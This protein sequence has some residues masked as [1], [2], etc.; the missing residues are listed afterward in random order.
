METRYLRASLILFNLAVLLALLTFRD[1]G[2]GWDEGV[3]HDYGELILRY[4]TTGFEDRTAQHFHN[5]YLY[6]GLFEL[7]AA[8]ASHLSPLEVHETRHLLNALVGIVAVLG[9]WKIGRM[10]GGPRAAFFA[11][12]LL[13]LTPRFTGHTFFNS[14]DVPFAAGYVWS[15]YFLLRLLPELPRPAI[16]SLLKLGAAIG[17]TLAVRAGALVLFV[18]LGLVFVLA[19]VRVVRGPARGRAIA[20]TTARLA[21]SFVLVYVVAVLVMLPFWPW[22][23]LD[24]LVHPVLSLF[25]LADFSGWHGSVLFLGERIDGADLPP[26]YIPLL[27][28][29]TL[30]EGILLV[31]AAGG[32]LGMS[33]LRGFPKRR[34][35]MDA[36]R[37]LL[38][39]LTVAFPIV[40]VIAAGSLLYNGLRH[41]LFVLPPLIALA[42]SAVH[43]L[44]AH[45]ESR[46]PRAAKVGLVAF[47]LVLAVHAGTLVRLHPYQF[48]YF[49]QLVGGVRGA[50]GRFELD[51][52]GV[53]L[54]E[55]VERLEAHLEAEAGDRRPA[56][57]R[58]AV[59]AKPRSA[60]TFFP[61]YLSPASRGED[62]DFFL[63]LTGMEFETHL[64]GE[65]VVTV[66]R[67]GATLATVRDRRRLTRGGR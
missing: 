21:G 27:L 8:T 58:V 50:E 2:I 45:L 36:V 62:A 22:A 60:T 61:D 53:T 65:P 9:C 33:A 55:A 18:Y 26:T 46:S 32:L 67:L 52:W 25:R 44:L 66:E 30:P 14:K 23:Q 7:M 57:Y 39:L 4:Y 13:L 24:P 31:L 54:R 43:A 34:P 11:A 42:G 59:G 5:L 19:A 35:T 6:G 29:F 37:H 16:P 15:V 10:L 48:V 41:L 47:G 51:Y 49:N 40:Y 28:L 63:D 38:V 56:E 3:Q 20:G 64:G 1:H 17:L 12:L